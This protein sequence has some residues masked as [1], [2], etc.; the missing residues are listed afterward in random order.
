MT[1][2]GNITAVFNRL[3]LTASIFMIGAYF[4]VLQFGYFFMLEVFLTSRS[5]SY[6]IALFFW[7]LGFLIGLNLKKTTNYIILLCGSIIAY[8]LFYFIN[9]LFPFKSGA[10]IFLGLLILISGICPGYFFIQFQSIYKNVKHL[11]FIE[12]NGFILGIIISLLGAI[13]MGEW[14][15]KFAPGA[16]GLI[17]LLLSLYTIILSQHAKNNITEN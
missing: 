14:F 1:N 9:I 8:Y 11:F 5:I 2:T 16:M 7:L 15:I 12:N 17:A 13:N 3:I 6:F 10:L 4:A